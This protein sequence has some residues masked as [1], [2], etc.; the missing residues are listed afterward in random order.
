MSVALT[1]ADLCLTIA[2]VSGSSGLSAHPGSQRHAMISI[3]GRDIAVYTSDI[4][5]KKVHNNFIM[6]TRSF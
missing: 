5:R 2:V 3:K 6:I 4:I 1:P